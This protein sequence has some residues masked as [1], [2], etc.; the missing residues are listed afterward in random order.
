MIYKLKDTDKIEVEAG[1]LR[2]WTKVWCVDGGRFYNELVSNYPEAFAK[3]E[4]EPE[5]ED[6]TD[7]LCN[8]LGYHGCGDHVMKIDNGRIWRRK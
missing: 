2:A 1:R 4:P 5:W 7:R 6:V 3:I 8:V